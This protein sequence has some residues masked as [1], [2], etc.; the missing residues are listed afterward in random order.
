MLLCKVISRW[1]QTDTHEL[2][3]QQYGLL[4]L[5]NE[6]HSW[7]A[8]TPLPVFVRGR[9]LALAH[10]QSIFLWYTHNV[11]SNTLGSSPCCIVKHPTLAMNCWY[12]RIWF[13]LSGSVTGEL[14]PMVVSV[15][16]ERPTSFI[17]VSMV[18]AIFLLV[19]VCYLLQLTITKFIWVFFFLGSKAPNI[20]HLLYSLFYPLELDSEVKKRICWILHSF[21]FSGLPACAVHQKSTLTCISKWTPPSPSVYN[22]P[23]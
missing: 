4:G 5:R 8:H 23:R 14:S 13:I 1:S 7:C 6:S 10:L 21:C 20:A 2:C 17:N 18:Q 11:S 3:S 16:L 12:L 19:L 15:A 9:Q 22:P